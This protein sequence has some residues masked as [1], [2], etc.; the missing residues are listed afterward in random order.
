MREFLVTKIVCSKCGSNLQLTNDIH[1]GVGKYSHG[2]PTGAD[3]V[4][5][6]IVVEPCECSAK[7][8]KEIRKAVNT[9]LGLA[10]GA[11]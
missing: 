2:E 1:I 9:L 10:N 3:M 8:L 5:Q 6:I 11:T 7:P 4:Q